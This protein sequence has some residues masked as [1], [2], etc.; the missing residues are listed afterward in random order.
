L[1][2]EVTELSAEI[3]KLTLISGTLGKVSWREQYEEF[4]VMQNDRRNAGVGAVAAAASE[5][6]LAAANLSAVTTDAGFKM[7]HFKGHL[8]SHR[9]H[10][11]FYQPDFKEGEYLEAVGH[12]LDDGTFE[13]LAIRRPAGRR[14]WLLPECDRGHHALKRHLWRWGIIIAGVITPSLAAAVIGLLI[15]KFGM[16]RFLKDWPYMIAMWAFVS[17]VGGAICAF[18]SWDMYRRTKRYA[19]LASGIFKAFGYEHPEDTDVTKISSSIIKR[20]F[21][22]KNYISVEVFSYLY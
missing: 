9:V 10:G 16:D 8:G 15:Y 17:I 2:D 13:V 1:S 22:E 19:Y 14:L 4:L 20:A 6:W 7:S 11:R 18:T 5:Q 12:T 21:R 3:P